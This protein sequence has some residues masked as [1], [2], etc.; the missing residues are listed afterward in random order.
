LQVYKDI[1]KYKLRST[2]KIDQI[3]ENKRFGVSFQ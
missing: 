1:E 2:M 3:G